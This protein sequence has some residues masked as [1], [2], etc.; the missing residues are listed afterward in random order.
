MLISY[1]FNKLFNE[2]YSFSF[3]YGFGYG[4]IREI[5]RIFEYESHYKLNAIRLNI[6]NLDL[7]DEESF[8]DIFSKI[9]A[10]FI[11]LFCQGLSSGFSVNQSVFGRAFLDICSEWVN[12]DLKHIGVLGKGFLDSIE[13]VNQINYNIKKHNSE[14]AVLELINKWLNNLLYKNE[15]TD[16]SLSLLSNDNW[17]WVL[18]TSKESELPFDNFLYNTI[19][20]FELIPDF[21][22]GYYF[23]RCYTIYDICKSEI[24]TCELK[25]LTYE[26][27]DK[28][29]FLWDLR[30]EKIELREQEIYVRLT[31]NIQGDY[32][33]IMA[34]NNV[35]QKWWK[36][37]NWNLHP[38]FTKYADVTIPYSKIN[39]MGDNN[40][41]I[42]VKFPINNSVLILPIKVEN[43][44]RKQFVMKSPSIKAAID[45]IMKC[46]QVTNIIDH[47]YLYRLQNGDNCSK[48]EIRS[49]YKVLITDYVN[50]L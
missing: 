3:A 27:H 33:P 48:E 37:I 28:L 21:K 15:L 2:H 42:G 17:A 9:G 16:S 47:I 13:K 32:I 23:D 49:K 46:E 24:L 12:T 29:P 5:G 38:G 10:D 4:F 50:A 36:V 8:K 25:N 40:D 22:H 19:D 44:P 39:F 1:E 26:L 20:Y 34:D 30:W 31:S 14:L 41:D 43:T 18:W 11:D 7:I 45:G 35:I 6:N